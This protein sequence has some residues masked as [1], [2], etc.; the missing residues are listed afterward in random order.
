MPRSY[1]VRLFRHLLE[2]YPLLVI[3]TAA[4]TPNPDFAVALD[5]PAKRSGQYL[6]A[7][8]KWSEVCSSA[9]MKLVVIE[10]T[11]ARPQQVIPR[12]SPA[13]FVTYSPREV[14][15]KRGKGAVEA[16]AM[17]DYFDQAE[18]RS[19]MTFYKCTGRLWV[20][21]A[22]RL[23]QPLRMDEIAVRRRIDGLW[24]DTRFFGT[25]CGVWR[26]HFTGMAEQ[27]CD[28]DGFYLEHV[29][30]RRLLLGL[31]HDDLVIRRHAAR[32]EWEGVSGT[33]GSTY[34]MTRNPIGSRI[35]NS[36]EDEI[37]RR[38]NRWTI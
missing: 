27:V 7:T 22:R 34:R 4:V 29:I 19:E 5:D 28:Q 23:L 21:N 37:S 11:G 32:P 20:R 25:T 18:L 38:V 13:E 6:S 8:A 3:L 12:G 24:A 35:R 36:L 9:G 30:A 33:S 1:A 15:I 17:D 10:T 31:A 14:D 2:R 16:R 26:R